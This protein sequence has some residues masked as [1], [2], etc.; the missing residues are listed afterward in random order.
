LRRLPDRPGTPWFVA[1]GRL[2]CAGDPGEESGYFEVDLLGRLRVVL[3][4]HG[5][6]PDVAICAEDKRWLFLS[7]LPRRAVWPM[8]A[9]PPLLMQKLDS[10]ASMQTRPE[11]LTSG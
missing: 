7:I 8:M 9:L 5:K 3:D 11:S 1:G 10:F 6:L 4:N 2:E